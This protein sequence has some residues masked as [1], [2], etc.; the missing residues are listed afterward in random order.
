MNLSQRRAED[1][2]EP[3]VSHGVAPQ[4]VVASGYGETMPVATNS[5]ERGRQLN[6]R[7]EILL[8]AKA[9]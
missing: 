3:L 2:G 9:S 1:G 8:K 6:R 4:R 5:S 7:V